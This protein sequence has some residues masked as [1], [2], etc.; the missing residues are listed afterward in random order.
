METTAATREVPPYLYTYKANTKKRWIGECIV[1][2]MEREFKRRSREYFDGAI[3]SGAVKVNGLA[4]APLYRLRDG[5]LI[6]HTIHRHEPSVPSGI[7]KIYEDKDIIGVDKP[8]GVPCHPTSLYNKNSVTEILREREGLAFVSV[9]NRLDIQ[10]S[11]VV[12]LAKSSSS[13]AVF[14]KKMEAHK[15]VKYYLAKVNGV[16]PKRVRV[17]VPL[18][19]V[20]GECISVVCKE[21]GEWRGKK[22]A[23]EFQRV[24]TDGAESLVLCRPITG[25]THQIRAHLQFIGYPI[26]NDMVYG[27]AI[28]PPVLEREGDKDK[29]KEEPVRVRVVDESVDAELCCDDLMEKFREVRE[30]R[31][32]ER[33][34]RE[35]MEEKQRVGEVQGGEKDFIISSCTLCTHGIKAPAFSSLYLHAYLYRLDEIE[36]STNTP[37]WVREE[38]REKCVLCASEKKI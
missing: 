5:D 15:V 22:C 35:S 1:D 16:F 33:R 32:A 38:W 29:D 11:G 25:R 24:C 12:V 20:P 31:E 27:S 26:S 13:A 23:T 21:E 4:V 30:R 7:S 28:Y 37:A 36:I 19:N 6:T 2:V 8:A 3:S 18:Y 14:H 34:E 9:I 10:T 17:E